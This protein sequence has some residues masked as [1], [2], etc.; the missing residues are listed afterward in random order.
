MQNTNQSQN[1]TWKIVVVFF[2]FIYYTFINPVYYSLFTN[3]N[4]FIT[5]KITYTNTCS[6]FLAGSCI[7]LAD[8]NTVVKQRQINTTN[9]RYFNVVTN[10]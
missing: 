4:K 6:H 2:N 7:D 9:R 3:V 5:L 10:S 8:S 1:D